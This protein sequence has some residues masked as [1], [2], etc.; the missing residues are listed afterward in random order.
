M[1]TF[2][3]SPCKNSN[4]LLHMLP[5]K[6]VLAPNG[7]VDHFSFLLYILLASCEIFHNKQVL[8]F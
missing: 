5:K 2:F 1:L 7:V 4:I 8:V 3:F 6:P